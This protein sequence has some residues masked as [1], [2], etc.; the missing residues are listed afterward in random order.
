MIQIPDA[1]WVQ[2]PDADYLEAIE[3]DECGK[4]ILEGE[5]Y[6]DMDVLGRF[7]PACADM[8]F[9]RWRKVL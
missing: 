7:C 3:C 9:E 2:H 5:E 1:P 8:L 6:I 4:V